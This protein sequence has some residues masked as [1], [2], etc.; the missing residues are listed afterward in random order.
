MINNDLPPPFEW[1]NGRPVYASMSGGKD[2]TAL[3]LWLQENGIAFTPVFL[4][5]GWEHPATYEY[6]RDVLRPLFGTFTVLRNEK[7]FKQDSEWAG[8]ME[9]AIRASR[10]FPSGVA[11]FCTRVLKIEPIQNFYAQTRVQVG[12]KPVN[13]VGIRAEESRARRDMPEHEEQDEATVWRPL[14]N[15]TEQQVINMHTRHAVPPNPLYLRGA[16][17]VGC[18]PCIFARKHEIRHMSHTDPAR[19]DHIEQLEARVHALRN[20]DTRPSFFKSRAKDGG[21]MSIRDIV[22]WS[23]N[24]RGHALEDVEDIE[25]AGCMRWGL[26]EPPQLSLWQDPPVSLVSTARGT[27]EPQD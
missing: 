3:A 12:A 2:S 7:F 11:K 19:I 23:R 25:E 10:M 20:D 15:W 21:S 17:R 6:I 27:Q 22:E 14:I 24:D 5:T 4:D 18:Y 16:A 13:C 1:L 8:G 9:Q 26:C